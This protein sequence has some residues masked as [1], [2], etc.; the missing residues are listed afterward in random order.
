[1]NSVELPDSLGPRGW[2]A[3]L[4]SCWKSGVLAFEG[5]SGGIWSTA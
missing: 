5:P 2:E 4:Q 1:M 3:I